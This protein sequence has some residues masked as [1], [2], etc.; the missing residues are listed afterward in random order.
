MFHNPLSH[1]DV[2]SYSIHVDR[3]AH[4]QFHDATL[5]CQ[6]VLEAS[7]TTDTPGA[8]YSP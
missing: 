2:P 8:L 6:L 5:S 7:H 4:V 3:G 1:F